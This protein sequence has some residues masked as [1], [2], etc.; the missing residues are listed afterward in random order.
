MKM[1]NIT[2]EL[3]CKPDYWFKILQQ[4]G[5]DFNLERIQK[6]LWSHMNLTVSEFPRSMF[7]VRTQ[8]DPTRWSKGVPHP[9]VGN[10]GLKLKYVDEFT[11]AIK[12]CNIKNVTN[13][14]EVIEQYDWEK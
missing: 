10:F 13:V 6:V 1:I 3:I 7:T 11:S 9:D 5:G 12:H 14:L 4:L 2:T 8:H